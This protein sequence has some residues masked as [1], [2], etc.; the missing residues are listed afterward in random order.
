MTLLEFGKLWET[1]SDFSEK[2]RV[3]AGYFNFFYDTSLDSYR[4][5]LTLKKKSIAKFIE[6]QERF[7]LCDIW[8]IKNPKL[9]RY[10]FRQK[11]VSGLIQKRLDYFYI[12]DFKP[13]SVKNTGVL[14][15]L[16]IDH[17]PVSFSYCKSEESNSGKGFWKFSNSLTE[18]EEYVQQMKKCNI[19]YFKWTLQW[20]H[21]RWLGKMGIFEIQY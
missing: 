17:S 20:K 14:A 10:T 6:T 15:S 16:L 3:L 18:N 1:I 21:F 2:H 19:R 11:H 8:K 13:V 7:D 4:D 9:K 12:S 5:K